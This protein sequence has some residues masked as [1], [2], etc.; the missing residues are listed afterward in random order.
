MRTSQE[1]TEKNY[2]NMV[3]KV[4]PEMHNYVQE[5]EMR[6]LL[7]LGINVFVDAIFTFHKFAVRVF[8]S[9]SDRQYF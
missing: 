1:C 2:Q 5:A 3:Q 4:V 6:N 7:D 9:R 8:H